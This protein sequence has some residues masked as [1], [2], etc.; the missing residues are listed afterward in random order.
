MSFIE[1]IKSIGYNKV[2]ED[3]KSIPKRYI[4]DDN[5]IYIVYKS[6]QYEMNS[7]DFVL[8]SEQGVF[9][10][11][12]KSYDADD[13]MVFVCDKP[14]NNKS[15]SYDLLA[16]LKIRINRLHQSGYSID[17]NIEPEFVND[18]LVIKPSGFLVNQF[19]ILYQKGINT[20]NNDIEDLM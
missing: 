10:P 9:C 5:M 2:K 7:R 17:S 15:F 11:I 1:L 3:L 13:L 4:A 12:I 16:D 20:N 19:S 14:S 8:L 6:S 18:R